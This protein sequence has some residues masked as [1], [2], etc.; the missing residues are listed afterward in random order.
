MPALLT[1]IS[2]RI[3]AIAFVALLLAIALTL[4]LQ[5]HMRNTVETM[6]NTKLLEI[7]ET[8]TSLLVNL[9]KGVQEGTYTPE[10]ARALGREQLEALSYGD[11]GYMFAFDTDY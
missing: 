5:K 7:T 2:T 1:K 10:E 9:E 6:Y 4:L 8:A 3:S 11:N